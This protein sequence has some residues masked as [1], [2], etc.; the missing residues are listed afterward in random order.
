MQFASSNPKNE[1]KKQKAIEILQHTKK[2]FEILNNPVPFTPYSIVGLCTGDD[3]Y[4]PLLSPDGDY[5]FYTYS[6][7][8]DIRYSFNTK[9]IEKFVFS[10]RLSNPTSVQDTFTFRTYMSPP[11]NE[12]KMQGGATITIDNKHLYIT[13]CEYERIGSTSYK[14]CDIYATDYENNSW[15]PLRK[16]NSNINSSSTFEGQPSITAD[17]NVLFFVSAREESVGKLD[18]YKSVK[19]KDGIWGKSE[20]LGKIINTEGDEKT[21]FIHS[22]SRTLYFASDGH[23]GMG[24]LDIFHSTYETGLKADSFYTQYS[25]GKWIE[26]KNIGYPIN[27]ENDEFGFIVSADGAKI[28]FSSNAVNGGQG[29]YDIFSAELYETA[30]PKKVLFLKGTVYDDKGKMETDATIELKSIKTQKTTEG[31]VDRTT[32]E[33]AVAVPVQKDED[34][35]ITARK[36]GWIYR[37][38]YIDPNIDDFE[39]PTIVD[40]EIVPIEKGSVVILDDVNFATN[41]TKLTNISKAILQELIA[42]LTE[43]P[44]MQIELHGHTD[45]I[46][47]EEHNFYLSYN[48]AKVVRDFLVENNI[49]PNRLKHKGYG[50]TKPISPNTTDEGRSRNRRT[51]FVIIGK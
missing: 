40:L 20:N 15:T 28:Y 31:I 11:F 8:V 42:F 39:T 25:F 27:T 14:N 9:P 47:S 22:D 1:Q 41:S 45:N 36:K 23:I 50:E 26:P 18:I 3:E 46:G 34:F 10:K 7:R 30:R 43:N 35:V 24:G 48:R 16:L 51:E 29:G 4:L 37:S 38:Q 32:G 13:I 21:P 12:G 19:G 44:E 2:Y 5:I 6:S 33:Y 49:N 17:G